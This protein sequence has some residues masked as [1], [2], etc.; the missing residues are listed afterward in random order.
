M[1]MAQ[2]KTQ[3]GHTRLRVVLVWLQ[4]LAIDDICVGLRAAG[5]GRGAMVGAQS[6]VLG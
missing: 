5:G 3:P 6:A 1:R 2:E 4:K